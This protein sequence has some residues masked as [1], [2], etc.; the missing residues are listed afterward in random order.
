MHTD[1]PEPSPPNNSSDSLL[2]TD[3]DYRNLIREAVR[4]NTINDR[5]CPRNGCTP[6]DH[7][8]W[9]HYFGPIPTLRSPRR[10]ALGKRRAHRQHQAHQADRAGAGADPRE[11]PTTIRAA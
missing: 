2:L 11:E 6:M 8:E 5:S 7:Y 9:M 4:K 1:P 3:S 10:S